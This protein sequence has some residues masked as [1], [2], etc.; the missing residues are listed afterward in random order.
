MSS[1]STTSGFKPRQPG[2]E[3]PHSRVEPP[4]GPGPR[5]IDEQKPGREDHHDPEVRVLCDP[6]AMS[7]LS[8]TSDAP[9]HGRHDTA[10][11]KVRQPKYWQ[12]RFAGCIQRPRSR[13]GLDPTFGGRS[14]VVVF[15]GETPSTGRWFCRSL[16]NTIDFLRLGTYA[17]QTS[18]TKSDTCTQ[19]IVVH[20]VSGRGG[21]RETGCAVPEV[22]SKKVGSKNH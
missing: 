18:Y 8:L 20:K 10:S 6:V 13:V 12:R 5:L 22:G 16:A 21:Y 17:N 11:T 3:T 4:L 9:G 7:D 15:Q 14:E 2:E 19:T 1:T